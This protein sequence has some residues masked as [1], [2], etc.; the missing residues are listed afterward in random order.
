M[1][2]L[3]ELLYFATDELSI[4][5][6]TEGRPLRLLAAAP[7]YAVEVCFSV[8]QGNPLPFFPRNPRLVH[9]GSRY[10][11]PYRLWPL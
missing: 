4:R 8:R 10:L 3:S 5:A 7:R 2:P 11:K 1:I 9:R 6:K